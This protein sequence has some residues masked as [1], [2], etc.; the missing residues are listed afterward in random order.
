M[1][2]LFKLSILVIAVL[3]ITGCSSS[4][5]KSFTFNI[6]NGDQI[7]IKLDIKNGLDINSELP[8]S[9]TKDENVLTMGNFLQKVGYDQYSEAAK[10]DPNATVLEEGEYLGNSYVFWSY[11]DKEYNHVI[12]INDSNTA[13]LLSNQV[14]KEEA[15]EIFESLTI[16]KE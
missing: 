6:D 13:L 10:T 15:K 11:E 9:I 3:L 7:K 2:K 16:T 5:F 8:F 1:R 4:L 12:Y 14:S